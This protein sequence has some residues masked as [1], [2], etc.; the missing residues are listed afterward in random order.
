MATSTLTSGSTVEVRIN[1][2][3]FDGAWY[4][5]TFVAEVKSSQTTKK[6]CHKKNTTGYLVKYKTLLNDD[7][8]FEPLTEVVDPSFVRPSPTPNNNV[9]GFEAGDVV[10]AYQRDGWWVGVVKSVIGEGGFRKFVVEFEN[11]QEEFVF[12]GSKLRLHADWI[13]GRWIMPPKKTAEQD[14]GSGFTTPSRGKMIQSSAG[15]K[16]NTEVIVCDEDSSPVEHETVITRTR[17]KRKRGTTPKVV[18]K[19]P[20]ALP[21]GSS[22][23]SPPNHHDNTA[24]AG[25]TTTDYQH[26][27]PFIK[28]SPLWAAMESCEL[29]LTPPQK[30]H[31]SPLKEMKQDCREGLAIAHMV[32]YANLVQSLSDLQPNDTVDTINTSLEALSELETHGFDVGSIRDRANNCLFLKLKACKDTRKELEIELEK[33]DHE[34][35]M[36]EKEVDELKVKMEELT[37]KM[38][39]LEPKLAQIAAKVKT[40]EEELMRVDSDLELVVN[41]FAANPQ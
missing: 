34:K 15:N 19:K 39:V 14:A 27:W 31:F 5:A 35:S 28:R 21:E 30:P 16:R 1:E 4:T 20:T 37:V 24:G 40:K 11:P 22:C 38:R 32:T 6:T 26:N 18:A 17:V 12:D 41:M 9:K 33:C 10:D 8:L 2:P 7:N 13:D 25:T 23:S 3:G 29:Y 36:V